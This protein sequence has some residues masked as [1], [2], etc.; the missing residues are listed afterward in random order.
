M[1][2]FSKWEDSLIYLYNIVRVLRKF[3][4]MY[5]MTKTINLYSEVRRR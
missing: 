4:H 2:I 1:E 5:C 3:V